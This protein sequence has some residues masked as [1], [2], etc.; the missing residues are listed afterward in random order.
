MTLTV[1]LTVLG[2][3][4]TLL[5]YTLWAERRPRDPL[6]PPLVPFPFVQFVAFL[7][8]ILMLA[9]LITIATGHPFSGGR[10]WLH[11]R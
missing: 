5:V 10:P 11:G 3:C 4:A 7:G 6:K 9:H 2:V 8:I 1:T